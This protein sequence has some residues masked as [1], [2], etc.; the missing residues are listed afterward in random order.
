[1]DRVETI[2]RKPLGPWKGDFLDTVQFYSGL[3]KKAGK[4]AEAERLDQLY[5]RQKDKR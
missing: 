5:T 2:L 1:M 3:L 4:T